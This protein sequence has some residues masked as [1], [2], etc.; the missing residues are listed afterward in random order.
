MPNME[1]YIR[2]SEKMAPVLVAESVPTTSQNGRLCFRLQG[3][4]DMI[5]TRHANEHETQGSKLGG[6]ICG[7]VRIL[8]EIENMTQTIKT[9]FL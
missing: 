3:I 7:H 1:S 5:Q 9:D 6:S 4:P 8:L 2:V